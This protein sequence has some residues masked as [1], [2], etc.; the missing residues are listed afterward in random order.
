MTATVDLTAEQFAA[1]FRVI[2][3]AEEA[4]RAR[5]K[6]TAEQRELRRE[7]E[8]AFTTWAAQATT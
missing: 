3:A 5:R 7:L 4:L 8:A 6:S 2:T 1:A